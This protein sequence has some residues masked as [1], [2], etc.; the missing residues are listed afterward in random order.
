MSLHQVWLL[1]ALPAFAALLLLLTGRRQPGRGAWLACSATGAAT[2]LAAAAAVTATRHPGQVVEANHVIAPIGAATVSAATR[3]DGLSA[4]LAVA[5]CVVS[6]LVQIYSTAYL[7]D[8]KRYPSYAGL[9]SLFSAAML[10]VVV[11]GDLLELLVGWEVM[12]ICSYF[13]I[14]HHWE[15]KPNT[16]AAISAF[17]VTR[18]GD[19]GFTAGIFVL[20][21][22]AG[23]FRI[24]T[25]LAHSYS[26][27]TLV[28]A[29]LL[30][31][32]GVV[33]K[34]AQFPLQTWLPDAMAG[35]TPVS[36]LIHAATMVAAGVYVVARLYPVVAATA[37]PLDVLAVISAITMVFGALCALAQDDVKKVLAWST[38]SQI[39]YMY[40]GLAVGGWA[41]GLF[42]LLT[43]A[44]FKALLFLAAGALIHAVHS[45]LLSDMGGLRR[46]M[47]VTFVT[48]TIGL[49]ALAGLPPFSGFFSKDG[50]LDAAYAASY[51]AG[52]GVPVGR[53][54]AT[55]VLWSGL[56]TAALTA[57]YATRLWL[58]AFFGHARKP[59]AH[60]PS[61]LMTVPLIVLAVPSLLIGLAH[62][63]FTRWLPSPLG[64]KGLSFLADRQETL[65][66]IRLAPG[67]TAVSSTVVVLGVLV[68]WLRWRSAGEAAD[69]IPLPE[70]TRAFLASGFGMHD[71]Y[72]RVLVRP[73]RDTVARAVGAFDRTVVDGAVVGTGRTAIGF[74]GLLRFTQNGNVQIYATM[75]FVGVLAI[76]VL[77][78]GVAG[79]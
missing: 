31:I 29:A 45:N 13:L 33:G 23:S 78:I 21:T 19:L 38:V 25:V 46:R 37:V 50:V 62:G 56:I 32:A 71:L 75:L 43:H 1:P 40:G 67:L 79:R 60:E 26:H 54:F 3:I 20:G 22:A 39:A 42:H 35:P 63:A 70:R 17:I 12:G 59:G 11:S 52:A 69:P 15:E 7:R 34:S 16:D 44:A 73:V 74:G 28:V 8:D 47:P 14:G 64:D 36:A 53:G 55:I 30:L 27:T 72:M 48:M 24:D 51:G 77:A 9:V 61:L 68:V 6:L 49:A 5:V 41:A 76:A 4:V 57:A 10:L 65:G 58:R 18:L 66:E 2:V